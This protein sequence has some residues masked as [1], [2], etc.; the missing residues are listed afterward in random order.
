MKHTLLLVDD[1]P[2][3]LSTLEWLLVEDGYQIFTANNG[4]EALDLLKNQAIDVIVSDYRMPHMTGVEFLSEVKTKYPN[5]LR[6]ILT[7]YA[8]FKVVEAAIN[9]GQVFKFLKK[10]WD[11]HDLK[12]QIQVAFK[13]YELQKIKDNYD[14]LTG[15]QN[16]FLFTERLQILI[17]HSAKMTTFGIIL[18]DLARFN[19]VNEQYG[20]AVGDELL[21]QFANRLKEWAGGSA[22]IARFSSHEFSI[23]WKDIDYTHLKEEIQ[24]LI[25]QC[26]KP[27]FINGNT[28]ISSLY[29]GCAFYPQDG[30]EQNLLITRAHLALQKCKQRAIQ[31]TCEFFDP[32]LEKRGINSGTLESDLHEALANEQFVLYYQPIVTPAGEIKELEALIRWQHPVEG[33]LTPDKF[34]SLA[35]ATGLI[36][37][38]GSWVLK[39]AC[40]QLKKWQEMGCSDLHIAVNLSIKQF[41]DPN[42][43]TQIT[44]AIQG[45]RLSAS[46]LILE[47]TESLIMQNIRSHVDFLHALRALGVQLSLDDFG[48][49]YSSLQYLQL[50]PFSILKIDKSFIGGVVQSK[51]SAEIVKTIIA[52]SKNLG[53]KTIAEGVETEAQRALLTDMNCDLLQGYLFSQPIDTAATTQLLFS[54]KK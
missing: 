5:T 15:L 35:E 45:S 20:L 16:R 48:T 21:Q 18:I 28:I 25:K 13:T 30:E 36:V 11:N 33:L 8:D 3:I 49:G 37:P 14:K 27:F 40:Y 32:I 43:Y 24:L 42:L 10:P 39:T 54:V 52:M 2:N 44:E 9:E 22:E 38:I 12:K 26:H 17:D 46:S 19:S 6:I 34:L 4:K 47:I 7:G 1:E 50:L 31:G 51:N 29:I 23:A 41:G 53:L